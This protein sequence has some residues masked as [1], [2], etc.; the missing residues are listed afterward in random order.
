M[1]SGFAIG[2]GFELIVWF[3]KFQKKIKI[4]KD[5]LKHI[6]MNNFLLGFEPPNI[7]K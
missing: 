4:K 3:P 6:W 5:T 7:D 1:N 2:L